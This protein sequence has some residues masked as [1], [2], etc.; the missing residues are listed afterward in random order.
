MRR[1][2]ALLLAGAA[3]LACPAWAQTMPAP[4]QAADDTADIVVT[5]QR[6]AQSLQDV[7]IS[8]TA[9]SGETLADSG[10]VRTEDLQFK[11]PSLTLLANNTPQGQLNLI[12]GVGTFSYSNAVEASVGTV[13]DGVVLGRQGMAFLNL[14]DV[15]RVEVLK[16]PQGTLFGKNASA[17]LISIVTA[18]PSFTPGVIAEAS[19]GN[20]DET[21]LNAAVTGPLSDSVAVR[22]TGSFNRRDGFVDQPVRGERTANLNRYGGR[23]RVLFQ[24]GTI[25]SLLLTAEYS[26]I[27]ERCCHWTVRQLGAQ[28][29]IIGGI[30]TRPG[31]GNRT[32]A[33]EAPIRNRS[34]VFAASADAQIDLSEALTLTSITGY[35]SWVNRNSGEADGT[36]FPILGATGDV[37]RAEY[38]QLSQELRIASNP[39]RPLYYTFGLYYFTIDTRA[40]GQSSGNLGA[41]VPPGFLFRSSSTS[42]TTGENYAAFGEVAFRPAPRL[43]VT[44]GGRVLHDSVFARYARIGNFPLPGTTL[45]DTSAAAAKRGQTNF[46]ARGIVQYEW[47][48]RVMTYASVSRGYKG[49]G[50]D[51]TNPLPSFPAGGYGATFAK[52]ETSLNYELGL[53]SQFLDRRVTL[54]ATVFRTDF[55]EFQT[56]TFDPRVGQ[57]VLLNADSYRTQGVEADISI[58]PARGVTLSGA[59][60]YLDAKT[61]RF[62]NAVCD[63]TS[64]SP[65]VPCVGGVRNVSGLRAPLAPRFAFNVSAEI[66]REVGTS[67]FGLFGRLD[68]AWKDDVLF[69]FDQDPNKVQKAYGLLNGRVG[70][71]RGGVR[72]SAYGRNLFDKRYT[73]LIFDTPIFGGYAQYPEIGRTYGGQLAV[74]F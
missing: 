30:V 44:A 59:G 10:I 3:L 9:L 49:Y 14:F 66:E 16:G 39:S 41:P 64:V 70:V 19:Y 2:S 48:P 52:P 22:L 43:L 15:E 68:Y 74:R 38:D 62:P 47:T 55:R 36:P 32:D 72:L 4:K 13:V 1:S 54:N 51:D 60:A 73:N 42:S 63:P 35:R 18:R 40:S 27:N 17:G 20:Y 50:A 8:I 56:T 24:P 53:R 25:G 28:A 26:Q 29:P 11:V 34:K 5:A 21:L 71:S 67:G 7:P 57:Y 69:N 6:R 58:R 46:V 33:S 45:G 65:G 23:A 12:R 37:A 31:A 61:R